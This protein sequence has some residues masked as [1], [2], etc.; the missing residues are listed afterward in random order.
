MNIEKVKNM[1]TIDKKVT[2]IKSKV[3][4]VTEGKLK[5]M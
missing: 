3:I 1:S 2:K 5:F 4:M